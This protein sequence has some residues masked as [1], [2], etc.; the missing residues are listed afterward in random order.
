MARPISIGDVVSATFPR[1]DPA[2]LQ[3]HEQQGRRPAVVV[4]LPDA[5]G[6]PRYPMI[7]LVPFT[8][9]HGGGWSAASPD[10][11]PRFPAGT[12]GLPEDSVC[13]IDQ[14]RALDA[15]RLGGRRGIL[16]AAQYRPIEMALAAIF[17]LPLPAPVPSAPPSPPHSSGTGG[18]T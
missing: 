15:R 18:T 3:G 4:G 1:P 5:L 2:A 10:L 14:A 6:S 7:F 12:P 9:D 11:Y 16:T 13:L 17:G 8:R